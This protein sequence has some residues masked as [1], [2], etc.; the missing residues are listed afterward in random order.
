MMLFASSF[1]CSNFDCQMF[2]IQVETTVD[3]Q[4]NLRNP[5]KQLNRIYNLIYYIISVENNFQDLY[6]YV[7]N[8]HYT[9]T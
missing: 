4:L 8:R 1:Q 6:K 5:K 3:N 7:T 2:I 9:V